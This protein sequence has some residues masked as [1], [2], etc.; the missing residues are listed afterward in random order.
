[1]TEPILT[2]QG[3]ARDFSDG[4]RMRRVLNTTDLNF[5]PGEFSI[6]AGPSGS[7][8]TTL[9]TI[10]GLI[11]K[12]SEGDIRLRGN[13][14]KTYSESRLASVRLHN[15][16][17]VFQLAELLPAL[18]VLE[19]VV[20]ASG[21]QGRPV[22]G[23]LKKKARE[24]LESFG[25]QECLSMMPLQLSGGQKQRVAIARALIN[26]PAVMLC[27]EPTSALDSESSEIVLAALKRLSKDPSRSI[28]MVTH[29]PRVFPYADRL[30]KIEN[31]SIVSDSKQIEGGTD[32]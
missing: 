30:I 21:I 23:D 29:D 16:G 17:F 12:P 10:I 2:L 28:I 11:L 3:I 31:G 5:F 19:N 20:V 13:S 6:I 4:V 1:M 15:Y 25:L 22:K 24:L 8:K 26:E 27:D 14:V 18:N 32:Q 7:G 9:L